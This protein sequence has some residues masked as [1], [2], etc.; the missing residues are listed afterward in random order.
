MVV[1]LATFLQ[2]GSKLI[3]IHCSEVALLPEILLLLLQQATMPLILP[4]LSLA[5]LKYLPA[6]APRLMLGYKL[7][8]SLSTLPAMVLLTLLQVVIQVAIQLV[9]HC[10]LPYA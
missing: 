7:N 5:F 9:G 1:L 6:Q 3:T 4:L 10:L 2:R 8:T